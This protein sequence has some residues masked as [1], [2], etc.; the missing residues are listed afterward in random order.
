[1]EGG[2]RVPRHDDPVFAAAGGTPLRAD[3]VRSRVLGRAAARA[4]DRLEAAGE[5]PLPK[6][7]PHALR[8]TY[9]SLLLAVGREVPYVMAQLGHRDP[10]LT[11]S[12]YA[13]LMYAQ[14]GERERLRALVEGADWAG[15]TSGWLPRA[16]PVD[17]E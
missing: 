1:M 15:G 4:N 2:H 11:L 3:N 6:L 13:G 16:L 7:T 8:R 14:E 5:P 10:K 12:V 17:G 9:C